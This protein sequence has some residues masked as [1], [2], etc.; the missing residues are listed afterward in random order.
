LKEETLLSEMKKSVKLRHNTFRFGT[1]F[2]TAQGMRFHTAVNKFCF[3]AVMGQ[4]L[5][6]WSTA[7]DQNHP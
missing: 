7:L 4:N 1:I 2:A 3:Q 5:T 6:V